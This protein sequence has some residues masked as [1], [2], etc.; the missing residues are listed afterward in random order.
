MTEQRDGQTE[1]AYPEI[2][3][4]TAYKNAGGETWDDLLQYLESNPAKD[5]DGLT[6][7]DLGRM[8]EEVRTLLDEGRPYPASPMELRELLAGEDQAMVNTSVEGE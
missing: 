5:F 4:E 3:I 1:A 7:D 8:T 6:T 2:D